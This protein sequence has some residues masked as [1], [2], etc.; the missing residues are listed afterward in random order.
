MRKFFTLLLSFCAIAFAMQAN[1]Q[2]TITLTVGDVWGDGSGYQMLLDAD[3]TAYGTTLP[4]QGAL[5]SDCN[6]PANLYNEFEYKIPAN[7]DGSC[8]TQ[9]IVINN[10]VTITVPAGTYDWCITNPTPGD[11]I[12]IASA[13]GNVGG[14]ADDYVFENGK[15][16]AFTVTMGSNGNDQV[17]VVITLNPTGPTIDASPNTVNFGQVILGQSKTR[18]SNVAG[19][20]LSSAITATTAA[21]FEVSADGTTFG[22]TASLA[23]AGGTLYMR[24]VPT[25][26]GN[27]N[28][29]VTLVS[30]TV[31]RTISLSG[32]GVDCSNSTVS[33]LPYVQDFEGGVFP[34]LCWSIEN[35][36]PDTTWEAFSFSGTWASCLGTEINRIEKLIT[37]P[38]NFSS[39]THTV[40]MDLTFMC[41]YNYVSNGTVDFKVYASTDGGTT[42]PT[43]QVWKL[44]DFGPFDNWTE[45]NVTI[46]LSSLAGQS[47]V[48]FAF[49]YD[50]DSCQVLFDDVNI[51]AYDNDTILLS[52][53]AISFP[54]TP[55]NVT[56]DADVVVTAYN[57]SAGIT[58]T[59]AAPFSISTDGTTYG[60]T[61]SLPQAGGN[62]YVRYAP[63]AAGTHTGTVTLTSGTTTASIALSGESI[64]CSN[65]TLPIN[66]TF[67]NLSACWTYF[68]ADPNNPNAFGPYTNSDLGNVFR[69]N[70]IS[71]ATDYT[72]YLITPMLPGNDAMLMSFDYT[73]YTSSFGDETFM[74]GTSS[75][76]NDPSAFTWG[77]EISAS[78]TT[79]NYTYTLPAG[80]KYAAIKYTSDYVFY[81]FID[82][83][84]IT[85][86]PTT[87]TFNIATTSLNFGNVN[88]GS[89][90]DLSFPVTAYSLTSDITV[91]AAAPFSVSS[92]GTTFGATATIA[93]DPVTTQGTVYVRYAPTTPGSSTGTVT[94]TS[95]SLT[96]TVAL[97]GNA[98]DCST[99]IHNATWSEDFEGSVFPP[100]CWDLIST[101]DITWEPYES[102]GNGVA[103]CSYD[104]DEPQDEKLITPTID[105]TGFNTSHLSFEVGTNYTYICTGNPDETADL[106][107]LVS[108]DGGQNW[109]APVFDLCNYTEEGYTSW[110]MMPFSVNL[111][112]YTGQSNVKLMFRYTGFYGVQIMLDEVAL[113]NST[114]LNELEDTQV[115]VYPNPAN[116]TLYVNATSNINKIEVFNMLGQNV[117]TVAVND[118]NASINTSNLSTGMYML[119]LHT[120]N[121]VVNQKFTVAR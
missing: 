23:Q 38:F 30:D 5:T 85:L 19:Y 3:H 111:S 53:N 59:T 50:G 1:A 86:L 89:T 25:T 61:A 101:N 118:N 107:V 121:G 18:T 112:S 106:Q 2:A 119:K 33:T 70:S 31:T 110:E 113:S 28:G 46:D 80:T 100:T 90:K 16:Y 98:I 20:F 6:V 79:N 14:R 116:S 62:L 99:A 51:Y 91:T 10:T 7:A 108:T 54:S 12:W 75:T 55:I 43:T 102:S 24:Y 4:A 103:S 27:D 17:D 36:H 60:A 40:L 39:Y 105:L 49:V 117:M 93:H 47:N 92:N 42:W 44:S 115:N 83:L 73:E 63:T 57:L 109:S 96:H 11:R 22:T 64:D 82:N 88:S 95:G 114:G 58:A 68:S 87:P 71:Q 13:N 94:L 48:R 37:V 74:V 45:T 84:N 65:I 69:F 56:A 78:T 120:D 52:S 9:N 35:Q 76:T 67:D 15:T 41:N 77:P 34:P 81:L 66:E 8:S 97:S 26:A 29:T 104:S 21:P 72:Q 32:N